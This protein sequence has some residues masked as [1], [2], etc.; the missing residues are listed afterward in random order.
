MSSGCP[1]ET[2]WLAFA[3]GSPAGSARGAMEVHLD[4]CAACRQ[5]VTHL[6]ALDLFASAGPSAASPSAPEA[7]GDDESLAPGD[8]LG[9]YLILEP[10]GRGGWG[11]VY[12][13]YDSQLHRRIA[14]KVS[15]TAPQSA[16]AA[17][18]NE[19]L[20]RE[21]QSIA[22]LRHP[23]VVSLY[24]VGNAEGRVFLAM[25]LM[26]GGSL[27]RWLRAGPRPWREVLELFLLAGAGLQAAHDVGLVHRDFKPENVLMDGAGRACLTDFGLVGLR[28]FRTP[29]VS[30]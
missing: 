10:L 15:R 30:C 28:E 22:Q 27:A 11:S 17:A 23:G 29:C 26:E 8:A 24:D 13:A 19:L 6:G 9:R 1:N 21:A 12:T 20:L 25:E 18:A 16:E 7:P 5:L 4:Q 14:L 2:A 3:A